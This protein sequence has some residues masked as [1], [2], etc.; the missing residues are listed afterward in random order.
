MNVLF[1][2]NLFFRSGEKEKKQGTVQSD[3]RQQS[4]GVQ[5]CV[6]WL[7]K[8]KQR[9]QGT[10][11]H[12]SLW[13]THMH[14]MTRTAAVE[15]AR[16]GCIRFVHSVCLSAARRGEG[17]SHQMIQITRNYQHF[18]NTASS[19]DVACTVKNK[20]KSRSYFNVE[21]EC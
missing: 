8:Q 2:A 10:W 4:S 20:N 16:P 17:Q 7:S 13:A 15:T 19:D 3:W 11:H 5:E 18:M 14:L 9:S 21:K 6:L 1:P 12:A